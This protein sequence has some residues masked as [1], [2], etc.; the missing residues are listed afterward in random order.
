MI[1]HLILN[2]EHHMSE[3]YKCFNCLNKPDVREL[4]RSHRQLN[5]QDSHRLILLSSGGIDS[6][7]TDR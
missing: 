6:Y 5:A 3:N 1:F 2:T 7:V 4:T